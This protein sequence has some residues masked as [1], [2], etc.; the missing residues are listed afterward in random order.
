[1]GVYRQVLTITYLLKDSG[2]GLDVIAYQSDINMLGW[3]C[4][5]C[6]EVVHSASRYW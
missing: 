2:N 1:M 3:N 6:L 4:Y 5:P